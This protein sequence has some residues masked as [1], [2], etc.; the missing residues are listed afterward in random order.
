MA[1]T[2]NEIV[3]VIGLELARALVR[4]MPG[5]TRR[6]PIKPNLLLVSKFGETHARALCEA[7]GGEVVSIPCSMARNSSIRDARL[8]GMSINDIAS[9]HFIHERTVRRILKRNAIPVQSSQM[10]LI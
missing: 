2:W 1:G 10:D 6:I 8:S 4:I 5:H 7:L 9:R 3:D